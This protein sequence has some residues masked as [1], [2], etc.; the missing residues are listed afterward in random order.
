MIKVT[1]HQN[2]LDEV[3]SFTVKGHANFANRGEDIVCAGVSAVT[4]GA[5]NA[6]EELT[7][8]VPSIQQGGE[9]GF[10]HCDLPKELEKETHEKIQLLLKGMIVSLQTIERD[11]GKYIKITFKK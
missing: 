4:F 6:I 5:V 1:I 2:H 11:Y 8:I 7:G 9:G 10:L 3:S